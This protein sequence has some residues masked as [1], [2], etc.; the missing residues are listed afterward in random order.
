M[1][2]DGLSQDLP[3]RKQYIIPPGSYQ[4]LFYVDG[5]TRGFGDSLIFQE[6]SR[7]EILLPVPQP[8]KDGVFGI[9]LPS[10]SAPLSFERL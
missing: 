10:P 7:R 3:H 1:Y 5:G 2:V 4:L 6:P 9:C 8:S